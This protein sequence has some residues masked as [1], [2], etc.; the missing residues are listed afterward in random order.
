MHQN[1]LQQQYQQQQ[2][3]HQQQQMIQHQQ[4][5]AAA[6]AAEI[7]QRQGSFGTYSASDGTAFAGYQ[8]NEQYQTESPEQQRACSSPPG[9]AKVDWTNRLE[10]ISMVQLERS[11]EADEGAIKDE[12]AF[13]I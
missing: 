2:L 8:P 9:S 3:L 4:Q 11:I 6:A 12:P 10:Q 5:A 1:Q 13:F 7:Q